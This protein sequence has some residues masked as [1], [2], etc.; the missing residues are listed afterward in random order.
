MTFFWNI[1]LNTLFI[2]LIFL[3]SVVR[4]VSGY[5]LV[6]RKTDTDISLLP[7]TYIG[8]VRYRCIYLRLNQTYFLI[9]Y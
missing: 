4:L 3:L 6:K 9:S 2:C 1:K 8:L 7:S 5:G